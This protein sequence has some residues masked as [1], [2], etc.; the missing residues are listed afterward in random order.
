MM[1]FGNLE[2]T[3]STIFKFRSLKIKN[4]V[5]FAQTNSKNQRKDAL[6]TNA[7]KSRKYSNLDIVGSLKIETSD[8]LIFE[9]YNKETNKRTEIYAS[10][11]HIKR[12]KNSFNELYNIIEEK[13]DEIY[14]INE[15]DYKEC[16]LN[17]EYE[18]VQVEINHL[19]GNHSIILIL[20]IYEGEDEA[21]EPGVTLFFNGEEDYITLKLEEFEGLCYFLENFDLLSSSQNL[22][23][24]SYMQEMA[25]S[26]KLEN[27]D[28]E[29]TE[30][31]IPED[32]YGGEVNRKKRVIKKKKKD[33]E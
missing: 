18:N 12:I 9:Y 15:D 32:Q 5:V 28:H 23:I 30:T 17:D 27:I 1:N 24:L 10:Y 3:E 14:I 13:R 19:V 22:Y 29:I 25:H 26:M 33:S 8:Y 6:Y 31:Y 7:Y 20:D 2:S 4:K 21:L 11:P 16:Y